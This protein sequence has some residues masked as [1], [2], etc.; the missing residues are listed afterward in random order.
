MKILIAGDFCPRDR[1]TRAFEADEYT[2]VLGDVRKITREVDYSIVNFECSVANGDALPISKMGPNLSCSKK[3]VEAL[4]WVGFNCVTLANN[5]FYD[6][7]N[8]GVINTIQACKNSGLD[9]VGGGENITEASRILYK[10]IKNQ[11]L[12]I[13]NCCEHE[14]SIATETTGGSNPLNPVQQYYSIKEAREKADFVFVIVH[15]G[16]E[17]YQLPSPRMKE[18]YRFFVDAGADAVVNHHQHCYSG[19]EV[20]QGKPIIYGLGNFCF[21]NPGWRDSNW[22]KGYM[23]CINTDNENDINILPYIQCDAGPQVRILDNI[24]SRPVFEDIIRLNEIIQDDDRL[25]Q[26]YTLFLKSFYKNMLFGFEPYKA[27][28]FFRSLYSRN[29]LPSFL[30]KQKVN[31]LI[32]FIGCESHL[33][34]LLTALDIKK[35]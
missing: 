28:R 14:F 31:W 21:D 8:K 24:D 33:P 34:K 35:Q 32:N 30:S 3:G 6:Y 2:S 16:N 17:Y 26:S 1:V 15:G 11:V 13:V 20:Y 4:R 5:H 23:V 10:T 22:N 18:L 12:A 19:Y 29:L 27:T 25:A 7:G 9:Y